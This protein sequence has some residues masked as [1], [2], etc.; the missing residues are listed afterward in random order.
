[1]SKFGWIF[2]ER[3]Y[4]DLDLCDIIFIYLFNIYF[5]HQQIMCFLFV[6]AS[7]T[8]HNAQGDNVL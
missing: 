8:A 3:Q 5:S 7:A 4:E 1:M 6:T 2:K